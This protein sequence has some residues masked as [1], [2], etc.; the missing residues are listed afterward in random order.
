[1]RTLGQRSGGAGG[2]RDFVRHY[3]FY[4]AVVTS[5]ESVVEAVIDIPWV[6]SFA[7]LLVF[8]VAYWYEVEHRQALC[9]RCA[10]KIPVDIDAAVTR[11][12]SQ[13]IMIHRF[14]TLMRT[15]RRFVIG[16]VVYVL[17]AFAIVKWAPEFIKF[18]I[19]LLIPIFIIY[20]IW[21]ARVHGRLMPWCPWCRGR[22]DGEDEVVEPTPDPAPE[23]VASR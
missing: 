3:A 21:A 13:L 14:N 12:R 22:D 5:I 10:D 8:S 17:V 6:P 19:N 15:R 18:G 2:G 1:M 16:S 4:V 23:N 7:S 11:R 9:W 20:F